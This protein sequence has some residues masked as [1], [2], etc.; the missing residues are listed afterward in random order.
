MVKV[1]KNFGVL[2]NSGS[3]NPFFLGDTVEQRDLGKN[4]SNTDTREL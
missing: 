1:F 4:L 3:K 2:H